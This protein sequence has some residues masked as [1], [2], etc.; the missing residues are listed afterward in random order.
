LLYG[1]T[2]FVYKQSIKTSRTGAILPA[3]TIPCGSELAREDGGTFNIAVTDR[4]ISRST[5]GAQ[6]AALIDQSGFFGIDLG[7]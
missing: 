2:N 1:W 7:Y 3:T 5:S 6:V 4:P